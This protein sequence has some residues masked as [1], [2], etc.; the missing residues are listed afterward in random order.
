MAIQVSLEDHTGNVKREAKLSEAA[1]VEQLLQAII[2]TLKLPLVNAAGRPITYYLAHNNR[3][4]PEHDTLSSAGVQAGDT[5]SVVPQMVA[6]ACSDLSAYE[7]PLVV[8]SGRGER[9]VPVSGFPSGSQVAASLPALQ[10]CW[11]PAVLQQILEHARS[12]PGEEVGG[13]LVGQVYA[14][15]ARFLVRIEGVLRARY[16][17]ASR[18]SLVFTDQTWLDLLQ[19]R[20]GCTDLLVPGWYHSHPGHGIFLSDAD[21]FL[22]RHFF[23]DQPWYLALVVDPSS[24]DWGVFGWEDGEIRRCTCR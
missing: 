18:T 22:H 24:E 13:L 1:T 5:L 8:L 16:T 14:E 10:I 4:L 23:A 17:L 19:Q 11:S 9:R 21:L 15:Q 2:P 3:R 6:G 7:Q 20:R 12:Q